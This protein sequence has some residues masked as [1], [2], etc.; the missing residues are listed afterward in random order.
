MSA[1]VAYDALIQELLEDDD[2]SDDSAHLA[3]ACRPQFMMCGLY[4]PWVLG[5]ILVPT[6]DPICPGCSRMWHADGCPV[7]PCGP[8]AICAICIASAGEVFTN[9]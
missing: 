1:N 4:M 5:V 3:C 6:D 7:C 2:A 8:G 9:G